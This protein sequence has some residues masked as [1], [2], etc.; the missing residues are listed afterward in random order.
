MSVSKRLSLRALS[1][2]TLF[3]LCAGAFAAHAQKVLLPKVEIFPNQPG[4]IIF[5]GQVQPLQLTGA[6]YD[7]A[8]QGFI[9]LEPNG[10]TATACPVFLLGGNPFYSPGTLQDHQIQGSDGNAAGY[11]SIA[12]PGDPDNPSSDGTISFGV[13]CEFE[14]VG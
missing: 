13:I 14:V 8:F 11:F 2:A 6:V 10:P 12:S 7:R 4:T 9:T 1:I 5:Q 3:L